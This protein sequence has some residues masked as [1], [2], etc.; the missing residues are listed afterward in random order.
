MRGLSACL[1][2][3][4]ARSRK[5]FWR[6]TTRGQSPRPCGIRSCSARAITTSNCRTTASKRILSSCPSS[7]NWRG[8]PASRWQPPTTP[9][10]CGR[11][12]PRCRASC[13]ASR[14][15]RPFRM[16]TGWSSRPTN[17]TSKRRMKCMICSQWC[18]KPVP[19]PRKLRT[20]A[21]L[22]STLDTP[23]FHITKPRTGWTIRSFLRSSAG[24]ALSAATAR[25]SHSPIR[26]A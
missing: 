24:T 11:M 15:A 17:F 23:K 12:T 4:Q 19:T 3:S 7:S 18:R 6:E 21:I 5:P 26:T 20:S 9:T 14:P 13:S 2:A 8:R 16:P 22:T 10:I 25:T 1:P